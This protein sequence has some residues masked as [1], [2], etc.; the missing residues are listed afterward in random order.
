MTKTAQ[1]KKEAK[2]KKAKQH[3][4][5]V[6]AKNNGELPKTY[7]FN[8]DLQTRGEIWTPN[9]NLTAPNIDALSEENDEFLNIQD[10]EWWSEEELDRIIGLIDGTKTNMSPDEKSFQRI[11]RDA[12]WN[13]ELELDVANKLVNFINSKRALELGDGQV[14]IIPR[15]LVND[16]D[17][18]KI[19]CNFNVRL[20]NIAIAFRRIEI[21]RKICMDSM[22]LFK[23]KDKFYGM[24]NGLKFAISGGIFT[25][26]FKKMYQIEFNG[27][28]SVALTGFLNLDEIYIPYSY[29]KEHD[30]KVGDI[31]LLFR[32]PIQNI[33]VA[34]R[35]A[36]FTHNEIR[37]NSVMF[38]WLGGDYDGDKVEIVPVKVLLEDNKEF[39]TDGRKED[40]LNEIKRLFPSNI[41]KD[42]ELSQLIPGEPKDS[43]YELEIYHSLEEMLDASEKSQKYI[44]AVDAKDYLENQKGTILNMRTVKD[45]TGIAGFFCN[46]LM[47]TADLAGEDLITARNICNIIQQAALDSKHDATTGKGY[48]STTWAKIASLFNNTYALKQ[49]TEQSMIEKLIEIMEEKD[50]EVVKTTLT[51]TKSNLKT[52]SRKK[53]AL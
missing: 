45:G 9:E 21:G 17:K 26:N 36:G 23:L 4:E 15:C 40:F 12:L 47:E 24:L 46:N 28:T 53:S 7:I 8:W 1:M 14:I 34:V 16:E 48:E 41:C 29:A 42:A 32:H 35:I 52:R 5:E 22:E 11:L 13:N 50:S 3:I 37:V 20:L 2:E 51:R 30:L 39:F 25:K 33:F 38:A 6:K 43:D 10:H 49:M 19:L 44:G 31:C 18:D 27:Y